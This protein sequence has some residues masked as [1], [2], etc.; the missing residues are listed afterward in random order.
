MNKSVLTLLFSL[1]LLGIV[2]C[3]KDK[4]AAETLTDIDGNV[5]KT[6]KIGTQ[7]WM[8]E[9][10]KATHFSNG[11]EIRWDRNQLQTS[12]QPMDQ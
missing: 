5:Y 1:S 3:K 12:K 4:P 8:A 10:L 6:V 11:D 2:A 7:T 9:N